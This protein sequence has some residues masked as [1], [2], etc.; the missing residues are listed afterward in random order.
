[1]KLQACIKET[2]VDSYLDINIYRRFKSVNVIYGAVI[3]NNIPIA[4]RKKKKQ[5]V[6]VHIS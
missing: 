4:K 1:M 6:K 5:K 2:V 3:N